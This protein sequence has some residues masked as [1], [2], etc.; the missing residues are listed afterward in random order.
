MPTA[1]TSKA[2]AAREIGLALLIADLSGYT[3]LTESH[4]ALKALEIVLRFVHLVEG[5]LE[6]GV[7]IVNSIGDDGF[8][9]G[10]G[11]LEVVRTAL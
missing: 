10:V 9:K 5:S 2:G 6:P 3:A 8:C 4:G 7:H 11:T 1:P